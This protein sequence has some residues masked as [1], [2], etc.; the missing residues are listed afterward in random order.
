MI[1]RPPDSFSHGFQGV[2]FNGNLGDFASAREAQ[3]I[4]LWFAQ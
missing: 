1:M 3:E 4:A 2:S